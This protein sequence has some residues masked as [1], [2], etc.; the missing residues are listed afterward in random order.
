MRVQN[1]SVMRRKGA[2]R[3]QVSSREAKFS[4]K[5]LYISQS[6]GLVARCLLVTPYLMITESRESPHTVSCLHSRPEAHKS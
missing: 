2:A 1:C 4:P 6:F 5:L 3:R